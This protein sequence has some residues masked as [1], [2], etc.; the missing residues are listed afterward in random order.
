MTKAVVVAKAVPPVAAP[1]HWIPVPV[2]VKSAT[3]GAGVPQKSWLA[4]PVG[5]GV[6]QEIYIFEI[7]SGDKARFQI[8]MSS[9]KPFHE[10]PLY[11]PL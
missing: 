11:G 1:Y 7:S 10:L 8:P 2:A 3:V 6:V 4:L 9:I 5:A